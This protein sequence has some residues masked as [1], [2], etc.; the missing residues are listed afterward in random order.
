MR[1]LAWYANELLKLAIIAGSCWAFV[2]IADRLS[3]G[4][5]FPQ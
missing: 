1:P 4:S 2:Q 3:N 5:A